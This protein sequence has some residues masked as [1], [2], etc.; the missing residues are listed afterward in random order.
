MKSQVKETPQYVPNGTLHNFCCNFSPFSRSLTM[1]T[2]PPA[3]TKLNATN[4]IN[5]IPASATCC[6]LSKGGK[7]KQTYYFRFT[8]V[9]HE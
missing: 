5:D 7:S 2:E 6:N 8:S 1:Y 3:T 4:K 9:Y